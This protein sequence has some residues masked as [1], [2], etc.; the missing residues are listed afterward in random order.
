MEPAEVSVQ[1]D[2]AAISLGTSTPIGSR[3][4]RGQELA[5]ESNSAGMLFILLS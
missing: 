1:P 3:P 2:R 4:G 5:I